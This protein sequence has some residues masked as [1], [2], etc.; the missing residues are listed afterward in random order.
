MILLK[1][2]KNITMKIVQENVL[3]SELDLLSLRSYLLLKSLVI[4][5]PTFIIMANIISEENCAILDEIMF[6]P[7]C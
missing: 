7:A 5:T 1:D 6:M 2:T 3:D 4:L